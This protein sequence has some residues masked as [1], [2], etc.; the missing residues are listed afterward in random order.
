MENQITQKFFDI[1]GPITDDRLYFGSS[2]LDAAFTNDTMFKTPGVIALTDEQRLQVEQLVVDHFKVEKVLWMDT[3]GGPYGEGGR[4]V[5]ASTTKIGEDNI[6]YEGKTCYLYQIMFTPRVYDPKTIHDAVKDG[7]T[8]TP[9]FFNPETFIPY[10]KVVITYSPE[11]TEEILTEEDMKQ[12]LKDKLEKVLEN[13]DDY[14]Q[15][16]YRGVMVRMAIV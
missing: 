7:C 1:L 6:T 11:Y 14:M 3:P 2:S 9:L 15:E 12:H 8:I 13:P 5:I 16:G 4:A 10:K